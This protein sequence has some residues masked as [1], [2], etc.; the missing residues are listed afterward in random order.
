[1]TIVRNSD[2]NANISNCQFLA[3]SD[4]VES[5]GA[6]D[7]EFIEEKVHVEGCKVNPK[8]CLQMFGIQ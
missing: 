1:M 5:K 4:T 6:A 8:K 7:E 3:P 2:L